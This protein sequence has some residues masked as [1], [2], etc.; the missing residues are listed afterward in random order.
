M[1]VAED[2]Q[3][4][5]TAPKNFDDL[6]EKTESGIF[7]LTSF[8]GWIFSMLSDREHRIHGEF[9]SS[10]AQ[11]L[12]DRFVNRNV[13]LL[14]ERMPKIVCRNLVH[15]Q[16][17]DI[18]ARIAPFTVEEVRLGEVFEDDVWMAP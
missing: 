9:V 18:H 11:R 8:V 3:N 5:M 1:F 13:V 4:S 12:L 2:R 17:D 15:V 14:G 16:T 6:A 7:D 10:A